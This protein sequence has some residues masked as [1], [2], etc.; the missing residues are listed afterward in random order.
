MTHIVAWL[1]CTPVG[2]G[3]PRFGKGRTFTPDSTARAERT[4]A[5]LLMPHAP[6]APLEGPIAVRLSY[7]LPFPKDTAARV[8]AIAGRHTA[9]PDVDNLAK[10]TLDVLTR[11]RWWQDDSQVVELRTTKDYGEHPGVRVEVLQIGG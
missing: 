1:D 6:R 9:K 10:L 11:L 7:T 5:T 8:A 4:Q 2:K 3:R